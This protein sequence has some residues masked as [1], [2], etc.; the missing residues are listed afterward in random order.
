M[1]PDRIYMQSGEEI[2]G[3]AGAAIALTPATDTRRVSLQVPPDKVIPII[4]LPGIM[5][6]HPY[7]MAA[8]SNPRIAI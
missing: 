8:S 1:K 4:F 5:G 2:G 7:P 6:S 3:H